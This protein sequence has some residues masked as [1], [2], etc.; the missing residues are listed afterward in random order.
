MTR[1]Q[2]RVCRLWMGA[3]AQCRVTTVWGRDG[4]LL[5]MLASLLVVWEGDR[6]DQSMRARER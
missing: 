5:V 1:T 4:S 3:G 2:N 6:T